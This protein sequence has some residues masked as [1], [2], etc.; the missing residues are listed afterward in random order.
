MSRLPIQGTTKYH[1]LV[2]P[3]SVSRQVIIV[4]ACLPRKQ[5]PKIQLKCLQKIIR[6]H[7][8]FKKHLKIELKHSFS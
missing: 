8:G 5:V 1:N 4:N 7:Q 2:H 6:Y 3:A